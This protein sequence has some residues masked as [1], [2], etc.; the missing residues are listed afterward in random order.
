M[1]KKNILVIL[2]LLT[3][4]LFS[5]IFSISLGPTEVE[6]S[7]LLGI[8]LNPSGADQTANLIILDIRLPRILS[9]FFVGCGLAVAG[10]VMQGLFKNSMADPYIIG[11]SSG[12]ALGAAI[13]IVIFAGAGLPIFAFIG[14]TGATLMVYVLATKNGRAPVETLLLS[15]VALSMFFSAILSF[16]MYNAGKS[17]HQ[18]VFWLMGG[19][20]NVG[21]TDALTGLIIIFASVF[22]LFFSR[23]LNILSLGEDDAG[24][25]GVN[26]ELLKKVLLVVSSLVAGIAV[27]IAGAI[28]FIGLITPHV[29]RLIVG[30]D[31]RVLIPSSLLAGGLF[32]LWADNMTRTFFNEMPVGVITAFVGAPFFLLLLRRRMKA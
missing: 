23:D 13:S 9:A 31:H 1:K 14:A 29:M 21:W 4:S 10:A 20:W 28:G 17:L 12:G 24:T 8:F 22:L 5:I 18:I 25:L 26:V 6:L 7:T 15:G 2:I 3:I 30:P 19:F 27:A 32:L 16:L 11:T